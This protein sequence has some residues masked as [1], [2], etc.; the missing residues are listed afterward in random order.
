M[1]NT[2]TFATGS[3]KWTSTVSSKLLVESGFSFNRERYDNLYQPGILADRNTPAWYPNVRKNDTSTGLLWNASSA[4]LGNYPD[5]YNLQG[6]ASYVTGS[7]NVKVGVP[8]PVGHLPPLQQR[9]RRPVPDLQQR[10]AVPGHGAEHAAAGAGESRRQ[11][12]HLRAGFLALEQ[13]TVNYGLRCDYIKQTIEGQ[14]TL[15]RTLRHALAYDDIGFP[16]WNDWSPRL[17]VVYDLFGNGKTAVRAGFNK[18]MTAPTTGFAR[19]YSPTALT[20]PNLPW[21]DLNRD[22]IAQGE[23]GC[24]FRTAGCEINFA[25]LPR[26]SACA[27]WRGSTRTSSGRTAAAQH[28][29]LA[30]A[31]R[32]ACRWPRSRF[33]SDFRDM[34]LR[35]NTL[36][37]ANSYNRFE[38]GQPARRR[39]GAGVGAEA[40]VPAAGWTT[41]QHDSDMERDVQRRGDQLQRAAAARR[42][43]LR[44][45]STE[46]T[47]NN[48]CAA[49]V[50]QSQPVALLRPMRERHAVA[51]AVQGGRGL[52]TAVLGHPDERGVPG[53]QRLHDRYR[54]AG[55]RAVHSGH[56]LRHPARPG[57]VQ[58]AHAG[59][60]R[61]PGARAGDA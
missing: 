24:A 7:H 21:A 47:L 6:A 36:L 61:L 32:R 59:Q 48:T 22:D 25:S 44:R 30:R 40:G 43:R 49:A 51:Q 37:D 33:R 9:Q 50:W 52:P 5:R 12:R 15:R 35:V 8:V 17:S 10:H 60:R 29:R 28:G 20:T 2:P 57:V 16:T 27:R 53:S 23:R 26:T 45:A 55:L 11:P 1:W 39:H 41:G 4:Q 38:V 14:P 56:R 18:F 31:V 13:L 58:A 54:G 3:V 19:L 42:P 46:R 34:T